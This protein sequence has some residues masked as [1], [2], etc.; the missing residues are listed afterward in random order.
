[1][2]RHE[3]EVALARDVTTLRGLIDRLQD[4]GLPPDDL[5]LVAATTL[6]NEKLASLGAHRF[7]PPLGLQTSFSERA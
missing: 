6:L 3:E 1:M 4:D 5:A 7:T 2:A